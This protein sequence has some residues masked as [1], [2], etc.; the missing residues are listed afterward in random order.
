MLQIL[1]FSRALLKTHMGDSRSKEDPSGSVV[2]LDPLLRPTRG[3]P[4]E[5]LFLERI[6]AE[7]SPRAR[8]VAAWLQMGYTWR[9]IRATFDVDHSYLRRSF[10]KE[11]AAALLKLKDAPTK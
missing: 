4:A 2:D 1:H 8:D 11:S 7:L 6:L 9:E 10:R 3:D 5:Q